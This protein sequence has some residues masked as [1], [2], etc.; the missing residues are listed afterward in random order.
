MAKFRKPSGPAFLPGEVWVGSGGG[1][2][3][4]L[5]V[6]KYHRWAEFISDYEVTYSWVDHKGETQV[7][8][9]DAWNFQVRYKHQS[10]L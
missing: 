9:K 4:I 10:D 5:S 6:R 2:V 8:S 3:T 7:H 1:R